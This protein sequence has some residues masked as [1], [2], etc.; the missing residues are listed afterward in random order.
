MLYHT[1]LPKICSVNLAV[2]AAPGSRSRHHPAGTHQQEH[3]RKI[4]EYS[5]YQQLAMH[6]EHW[7]LLLLSGVDT[8]AVFTH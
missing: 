6:Q 4:I 7:V 8:A 5:S 2:A 3:T 1:H